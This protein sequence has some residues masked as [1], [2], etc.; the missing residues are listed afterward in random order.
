MAEP[1]RTGF[2]KNPNLKIKV[3]PKFAEAMAAGLLRTCTVPVGY[4]LEG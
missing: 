2:Y 3:V 1:R 4:A